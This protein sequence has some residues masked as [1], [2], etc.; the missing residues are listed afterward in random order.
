[1]LPP[2][3]DPAFPTATQPT[4]NPLT[5][6]E[7]VIVGRQ[8][9]F[10]CAGDLCGYEV[11]FRSSHHAPLHIAHWPVAAQDGAA[12]RVLSATFDGVGAGHVVGSR[13]AFVTVTR[14]YLVGD[15]A[16]PDEPDRLVVA[17]ASSIEADAEVIAG[18]RALRARGFRI[19]MDDF[20]G[21][22]SQRR[23]LPLADYVR[24]DARDLDVEGEP[25]LTLARS[26]G[27]HLVA[28]RVSSPLMELECQSLGFEL[29]QGNGIEATQVL[30]LTELASSERRR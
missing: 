10:T 29:F 17:I 26:Y 4:R 25:L 5:G 12:A 23:L 11:T 20:V 28:D 14:S 19:A 1:M 6:S 2:L 13:C 3:L 22:A 21:A 27:A 16:L 15:R 18:V 9:I 8:G 24:I 30:D 7:R